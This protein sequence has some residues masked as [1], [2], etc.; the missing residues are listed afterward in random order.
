MEPETG[1]LAGGDVG[2]GRLA[3]PADI[4]ATAERV[5]GPHDLAGARIVVSAGG[6][7]EPIDAVRV[8]ANRSSG[9]QG[10]AI[11]AEAAA[12]GASVTL[13]STVDLPPPAGVV[14]EHVETAAEMQVA[15]ERLAEVADVVVMAAAVADFRPKAA[16]D[17]KLR[18]RDGVPEII[19]EPTPDILAGLGLR[20][21][22]GQVLVG[23]AA[24]T[25]DLVAHAQEKLSRSVSISWWRTMSVRLA[26]DSGT[27][28]M[29]SR[30]C[31]RG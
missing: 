13:V 22:P 14:I 9:K 19:L 29:R 23:F 8:I 25:T 4:V 20:K 10:Y 16:A 2:T 5:L 28:R 21:R 12:R 30:S 26:S 31:V 18:K 6:T 11:A 24:E 15:V 1:R 17:G 7:R 3:S 27:I